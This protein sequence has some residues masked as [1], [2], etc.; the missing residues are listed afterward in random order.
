MAPRLPVAA[1]ALAATAFLCPI[2]AEAQC[3]TASTGA[4]CVRVL[5]VPARPMD[6]SNVAMTSASTATPLTRVGDVLPRGEYS[7]ILNADYYGLPPVSD[8]WVYMRVGSD[9]FRVDWRTHEV[10]ERVTDRAAANF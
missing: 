1:F 10:L 6:V 5:D 9:A 3:R 7:I 8:G 4:R 2:A